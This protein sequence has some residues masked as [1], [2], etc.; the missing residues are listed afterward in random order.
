MAWCCTEGERAYVG[1][2]PVVESLAEELEAIVGPSVYV[3]L[4]RRLGP[5]SGG[6][7]VREVGPG[8]Q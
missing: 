8:S 5:P 7:P 1:E 2:R 4:S 3:A 6:E